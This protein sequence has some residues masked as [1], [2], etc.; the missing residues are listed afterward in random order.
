MPQ[1]QHAGGKAPVLAAHTR[2]EQPDDKIG[3]FS[4]PTG[5]IKCRSRRCDR[6]R[7]ARPP[8]C[9]SSRLPRR[10]HK[11][12]ATARAAAC[13]AGSSRLIAPRIRSRTSCEIP[14]FRLQPPGRARPR[15]SSRDN[16]IR[17]PA[18]N[19]P[20]SASLR[21]VAMKVRAR[22]AIAIEENAIVSGARADAA[23]ADLGA[24]KTTCCHTCLIGTVSVRPIFDDARRFRPRSVIG[25][26][27]FELPIRLSG[28]ARSWRRARL[29]DCRS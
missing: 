21:C 10:D 11:F 17:L 4:A 3:I 2:M 29:V 22:Q 9:R 14:C 28:S 20:G 1:V 19:H 25:D 13:S 16:R 27:D 15:S 12:C 23:V 8:S 7:C 6:D 5:I 26:D 18:T 24:A